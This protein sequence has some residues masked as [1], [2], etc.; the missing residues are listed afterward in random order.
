MSC[1]VA[2]G[3]FG[4]AYRKI[5]KNCSKHPL[6][7]S[8]HQTVTHTMIGW[9]VRD[10]LYQ[11]HTMAKKS[12]AAFDYCHE[13]WCVSQDESI[14]A[15][16]N[17]TTYADHKCVDEEYVEFDVH[18]E[19]CVINADKIIEF[20]NDKPIAMITPCQIDCC[21]GGCNQI[22]VVVDEL[23][24]LEKFSVEQEDLIY[25]SP[26]LP[27]PLCEEDSGE[28]LQTGKSVCPTS[29]SDGIVEIKHKSS[30]EL[31][32]GDQDILYGIVLEG[33]KDENVGTS[34]KFKVDN[35]FA[36]EADIFVRYEKKT[37]LYA[38]EP[39]CESMLNTKSGCDVDAKTIEVGCIEFPG[40]EPFALVDL[41]F[42]SNDQTSFI[43]QNAKEDR[44]VHKCCPTPDLYNEDDY[45]VVKY[46]LEIQCTCPNNESD[47]NYD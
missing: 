30:D 38:N 28:K 31:P 20:C 41:Y 13:N 40:K 2:S 37:G 18:F 36:T 27:P 24:E 46:T 29:G 33:Q 39:M 12:Q 14:M 9:I 4:C 47:I 16:P 23:V 35:I 10:K 32:I 34:I 42:V 5:K 3:I 17:G 6:D 7:S 11:F 8:E 43:K 22:D 15:Y 26:I 25:D 19:G 1:L 45:G 21:Y 44:A